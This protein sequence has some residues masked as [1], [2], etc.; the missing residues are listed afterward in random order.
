M[1]RNFIGLRLVQK[2]RNRGIDGVG[3][4]PVGSCS[5]TAQGRRRESLCSA[6]FACRRERRWGPAVGQREEGVRA[7]GLKC[8]L[9]RGIAGWAS[10]ELWATRRGFLLFFFSFPIL[11]PKKLLRKKQIK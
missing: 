8:A 6:G 1:L 5:S 4:P 9:G 3:F 7:G 10:G 2:A 11:F